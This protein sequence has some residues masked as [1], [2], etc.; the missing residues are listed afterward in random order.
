MALY[1]VQNEFLTVTVSDRG[2]EIQ[3]IQDATGCEYI[4]QAQAPGLWEDHALILFPICGRLW[5]G[6]CTHGEGKYFMEC[7]GFAQ[8]MTFSAEKRSE[9]EL[10]MIL[11]GTEETRRMYPFDFELI[12]NYRL[13]KNQLSCTA[14]VKNTGEETMPFAFGLHPGFNLPLDDTDF[15]DWY[16]EFSEACQPEEILVT[17]EG[18]LTGETVVRPLEQDRILPLSHK[19]FDINS[20][21]FRQISREVSMRSHK[22]ARSVTLTFPDFPYLGIWHDE[23]TEAPYLCIEPWYGMP[24]QDG[25]VDSLET[26]S[27]MIA[28]APGEEKH[29][30]C[31]YTVR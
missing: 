10:C 24:S 12:I 8:F 11:R 2:A 3:S 21:L 13:D 6:Y 5:D 27:D 30:L 22:S 25:Q 29:F 14:S 26:K 15:S 31:V 19:L 18:F 7:H 4:W 9:N 16:L 17:E 1:T 20:P 28:L 23:R